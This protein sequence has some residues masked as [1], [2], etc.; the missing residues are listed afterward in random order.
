MNRILAKRYAFCD[1]SSIVGFPNQVPSRDEWENSLPRFHGEEWEVPAEHLL[2]F[3]EFIDRLEIV[4]EDV[5]IKLFKFSLEGIG[6]DWCRSLPDA[7]IISLAEFHSAFHVFC[8]DHFSANLLFPDCCHEFNLSKLELQ[9]EYVAEEDTLHHDQKLNDSHYDNLS[10]AFDTIS[11]TSTIVS[12]HEDQ[13]FISENLEDVEQTDRF[14][15]DSF[16]SAVVKKDS[17]QCPDLQGLSNFLLPR[18]ESAA[19]VMGSP[20]LLDLQ[21]KEI[22]SRYEEEGEDL[23]G[24]DQQSVLYVSPAE[25]PQPTFNR[26]TNELSQQQ[27]GSQLDQQRGEVFHHVFHDPFA[28]YLDSMSSIDPRIFLSKGDYFYHP[29]KSFFCMIW[30]SLLLGSRSI[31][32]TENQFLTWLHWKHAF[33]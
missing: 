26:E 15:S 23:K 24:P 9:E 8:K 12:C 18:F 3:H 21:K 33:T 2:D 6:L 19:Y 1:F 5:K 16:R 29:L 22:L 20:H 17:L 25:I 27:F 30:S 14:T 32:M 7:S 11:N 4:H 10:D 28:N 31:I 13:V